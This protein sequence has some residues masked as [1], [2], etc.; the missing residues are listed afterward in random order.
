MKRL[1]ALALLTMTGVHGAFAADTA[2]VASATPALSVAP[3]DEYTSKECPAIKATLAVPKGW[4]FLELKTPE[5][6]GVS[7]LITKEKVDNEYDPFQTGL[8][9]NVIK[10]VKEQTEM[11]PSEYAKTLLAESQEKD[12]S[13]KTE[14][15][16]EAPF[17]VFKS[18]QVIEADEGKLKIITLLKA[19][20]ET[21]TLYHFT[22]QY[23]EAQE[24]EALETWKAILELNKL[25]PKF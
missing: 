15:S 22:W 12:E 3:A 17:K 14:T 18:T 7:Y 21:G 20:D 13:S 8:S 2:P 16:E 24:K 25:D 6:S 1:A 9:L 10:S 23:P 19:N 11:D 5:E 4:T